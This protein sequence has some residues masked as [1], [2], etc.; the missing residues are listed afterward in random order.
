[1][2]Y[3]SLSGYN[4]CISNGYTHFSQKRTDPILEAKSNI[5]LGIPVPGQKSCLTYIFM[6]QASSAKPVK[7]Y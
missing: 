3:L 5:Q 7:I 2:S 6:P 4:L 1:M